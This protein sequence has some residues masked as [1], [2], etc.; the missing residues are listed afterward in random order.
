MCY[1]SSTISNLVYIFVPTIR[2][3][4]VTT[5]IYKRSLVTYMIKPQ[6]IKIKF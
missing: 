1:Y 4:L 6:I 3:V 5:V 2:N